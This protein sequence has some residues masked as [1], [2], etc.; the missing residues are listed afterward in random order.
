MSEFPKTL[1]CNAVLRI[2]IILLKEEKLGEHIYRF[3]TEI[4]TQWKR[5]HHFHVNSFQIESNDD[6]RECVYGNSVRRKSFIE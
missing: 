4:Y 1:L 6:T 5:G 3:E 2:R